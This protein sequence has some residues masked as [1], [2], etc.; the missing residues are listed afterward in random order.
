MR[1]CIPKL[2]RMKHSA[3]VERTRS[4]GSSI[5]ESQSTTLTATPA[6]THLTR[7]SHDQVQRLSVEVVADTYVP[8][9]APGLT[10]SRNERMRQQKALAP[11]P[12][13][14]MCES[15]SSGIRAKTKAPGAEVRVNVGNWWTDLCVSQLWV[16]PF[17]ASYEKLKREVGA[18][19]PI[20]GI[21]GY[22]HAH[23]LRTHTHGWDADLDWR[24]I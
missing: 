18:P 12:G 23:T 7:L 9:E 6:P 3:T 14:E 4:R 20:P 19:C 22:T 24:P 15:L 16:P 10:R 17:F 13:F 5:A 21:D 11:L 1:R 2:P 8:E